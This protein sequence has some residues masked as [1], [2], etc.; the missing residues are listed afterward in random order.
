MEQLLSLIMFLVVIFENS[1]LKGSLGEFLDQNLEL[2]LGLRESNKTAIM[3]KF[4]NKS[5]IDP[6]YYTLYTIQYT[7]Y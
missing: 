4:A 3:S 7:L 1:T 6:P 5:K 2:F